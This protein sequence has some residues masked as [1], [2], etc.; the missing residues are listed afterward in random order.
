MVLANQQVQMRLALIARQLGAYLYRY[1]NEVQLHVSLAEVLS[2]H[3]HAFQREYVLD[4]RNRAD[5]WLDGLVVEVKV[6]GTYAQALRQC[7]RY[8][9]LPQVTGV[10]LASTKSWAKLQPDKP[11]QDK[12]F[13]LAYL[14]R[15][16][17]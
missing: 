17:L 11:W 8:L 2:S 14:G 10:L 13:E 5:F 16:S 4:A 15:Q 7:D 12:P 1:G 6:D 9:H 3:G